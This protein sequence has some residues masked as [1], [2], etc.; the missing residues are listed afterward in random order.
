MLLKWTFIGAILGG[1]A[2]TIYGTGFPAGAIVGG[3]VLF[4]LRRWILTTFW[5]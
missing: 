5:S 1:I 2:S 4:F 3:V